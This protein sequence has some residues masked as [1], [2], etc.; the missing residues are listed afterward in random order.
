M[1]YT[2]S[3]NEK[4][5]TVTVD[6]KGSKGVAKCCPTDKFDI[7][8][9]IELALER[10]KVVH[11]ASKANKEAPTAPTSI[12]G[13]VEALEKALP[14]GDMVL[15]GNGTGLTEAQKKWLA[16]LAGDCYCEDCNCCEDCDNDAEDAYD[17]GYDRGRQDGYTEGYD[18]GVADGNEEA[19]EAILTAIYTL[20]D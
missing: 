12:I 2:V 1:K 20:K 7:N 16:N 4:S 5:R 13:L 8:V 3:I 10:A 6:Y 17:E 15:V 19:T 11:K 18:D 9:G 14:K